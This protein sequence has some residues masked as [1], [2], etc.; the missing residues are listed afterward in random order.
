MF[1]NYQNFSFY[2]RLSE[3]HTVKYKKNRTVLKI[4]KFCIYTGVFEESTGPKVQ[5]LGMERDTEVI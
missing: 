3:G 4:A 1:L 5:V 2:K